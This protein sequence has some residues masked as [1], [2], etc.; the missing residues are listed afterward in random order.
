M[1]YVVVIGVEMVTV[2]V[3][4]TVEM[5]TV[6]V[7]VTVDSHAVRYRVKLL[8]LE[9][10][11]SPPS[12]VEIKNVW[13]YNS[14]P[15]YTFVAHCTCNMYWS[16]LVWSGVTLKWSLLRQH[17][18]RACTGLIWVFVSTVMNMQVREVTG[19]YSRFQKLLRCS[20]RS[21]LHIV[22]QLIG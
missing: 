5:V 1:K 19:I 12:S 7:S 14:S 4:V 17:S 15:A 13:S 18:G 10:D 16:G 21:L 3:S 8:G 20:R 6:T 22:S 9:A 11:R 2:T